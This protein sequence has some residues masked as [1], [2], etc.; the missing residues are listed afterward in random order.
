MSPD[1]PDAPLVSEHLR[2]RRRP[3][4]G[5]EDKRNA[6]GR[7][8]VLTPGSVVIL[9]DLPCRCCEVSSQVRS[10]TQFYFVGFSQPQIGVKKVASR[11]A[12][13]VFDLARNTLLC[14][15]FSVVPEATL[16]ASQGP[17]KSAMSAQKVLQGSEADTRNNL[18]E[19]KRKVFPG[20]VQIYLSSRQINDY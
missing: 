10:L 3:S 17:L 2:R 14:P 13:S 4:T 19:Q 16:K 1:W 5:L 11:F 6:V 15:S 12:S 9:K 8:S 20:R 7:M 18:E